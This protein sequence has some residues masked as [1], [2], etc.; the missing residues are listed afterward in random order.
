[1]ALRQRGMG[2]RRRDEIPEQVHILDSSKKLR[3]HIYC[4]NTWI[5]V[6]KNQLPALRCASQIWRADFRG[7]DACDR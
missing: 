3:C 4:C 6:K 7:I 2:K 1:M 5:Q